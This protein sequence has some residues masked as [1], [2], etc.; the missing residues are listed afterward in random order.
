MKNITY[1]F[2]VCTLFIFISCNDSEEKEAINQKN[3]SQL[4]LGEEN[5]YKTLVFDNFKI[6]VLKSM[7]NLDLGIDDATFQLSETDIELHSILIEESIES[8]DS[9]RKNYTLEDYVNL[10]LNNAIKI[11]EKAKIE[12]VYE[13]VQEST[14]LE[15]VTVIIRGISVTDHFEMYC[16]LTIYKTN[17]SFYNY[18]TWC[19]AENSEKIAPIMEKMELSFEELN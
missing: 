4:K 18:M 10:A 5:F 15:F 11:V 8:L 12:P 17:K 19:L 13:T 7:S 16:R 2:L 9:L 14:N 1:T 6:D 3:E